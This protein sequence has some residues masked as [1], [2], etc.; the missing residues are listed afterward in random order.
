MSFAYLDPISFPSNENPYEILNKESCLVLCE[1]DF[2]PVRGGG[3]QSMDPRTFDSPR[4]QRLTLDRP[5][6]K[7]SNTQPLEDIYGESNNHC[8]TGFYAD[9]SSIQGGNIKYYTDLSLTVYNDP[10]FILPSFVNL[11]VQTDPMGAYLPQYNRVP[12]F[13]KNRQSSLYSFDQ[14]QMEFREDLMSFQTRKAN[15]SDYNY[16]HDFNKWVQ[17]SPTSQLPYPLVTQEVKTQR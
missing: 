13:Q 11:H 15:R 14:D 16:Y 9:Y 1:G 2:V 17:M 7:I 5:P 12:I 4:A 10:V 8:Q 3:Y 6:L